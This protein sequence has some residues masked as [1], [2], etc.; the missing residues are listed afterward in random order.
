VV[1]GERCG[2]PV[3]ADGAV[4][5]ELGVHRTRH[6]GVVGPRPRALG[7]IAAPQRGEVLGDEELRAQRI[8]DPQAEER[9]GGAGKAGGAIVGVCWNRGS[10]GGRDI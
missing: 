4:G 6:L 3:L 5:G 1:E 2:Q 9:T 7:Q 10:R 8:A